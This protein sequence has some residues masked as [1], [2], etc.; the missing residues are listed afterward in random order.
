[1]ECQ[2][3]ESFLLTLLA[4]LA[5]LTLLADLVLAAMIFLAELVLAVWFFLLHSFLLY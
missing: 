4:I 2:W 3:K 1:M 5:A